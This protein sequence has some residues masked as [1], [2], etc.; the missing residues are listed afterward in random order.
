MK[1]SDWK[2]FKIIK[3]KAIER[4]CNQALAEFSG[5]IADTNTQVHSRYL[6]LYG[7]VQERDREMAQLFNGHSRYRA[8]LQLLAMRSHGLVEASW[9]DGLSDEFL[10]ETDPSRLG[11]GQD[12]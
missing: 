4:F 1:E 9:L 12:T 5:V 11:R 2:K 8:P 7:L 3:E 6:E 10:D